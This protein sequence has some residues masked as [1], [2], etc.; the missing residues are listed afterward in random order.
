MCEMKFY[1]TEFT[2]D[3]KYNGVLCNRQGLLE[4]EISSKMVIH[5]VLITT[6]GLKYNE[7]SG[8]FD[9]VITLEELFK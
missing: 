7:Y 2:V 8:I 4:K 9:N 3:K 1:S 5:N 6:T